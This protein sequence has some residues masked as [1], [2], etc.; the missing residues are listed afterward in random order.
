MDFSAEPQR[1]AA[2]RKPATETHKSL[3]GAQTGKTHPH[4]RLVKDG[5]QAAQI[6]VQETPSESRFINLDA[7]NNVA[8]KVQATLK[9][10]RLESDDLDTAFHALDEKTSFAARTAQEQKNAARQAQLT[11]EVE[12]HF[13]DEERKVAEFEQARRGRGVFRKIADAASS[14]WRGTTPEER[15]AGVKGVGGI[16]GLFYTQAQRQAA[17]MKK[18]VKESEMQTAAP[19]A[20]VKVAAPQA[21]PD[22]LEVDVDL[23]DL[24]TADSD[25]VPPPSISGTRL[26]V[27]DWTQDDEVQAV[28]TKPL[29]S[30]RRKIVQKQN[31]LLDS[32]QDVRLDSDELD[33]A[34]EG[35]DEHSAYQAK[36]ANEVNEHVM[37]ENRKVAEFEATR[38]GRGFF[39]KL[40]D[41]ASYVWKGTTPEERAAGD[42]GVGGIRSLFYTQAQRQAAFLKKATFADE[43]QQTAPVAVRNAKS[44]VSK[45]TASVGGKS[46]SWKTFRKV[47]LAGVIGGGAVTI[48]ISNCV[49]DGCGIDGI[50]TT[51]RSKLADTT[52]SSGGGGNGNEVSD[53]GVGGGSSS[54]SNGRGGVDT[55]AGGSSSG[56]VDAGAGGS[57]NVANNEPPVTPV[58]DLSTNTGTPAVP[59]IPQGT[60]GTTL[61]QPGLPRATL[62]K[63]TPKAPETPKN[64]EP[65]KVPQLAECKDNDVAGVTVIDCVVPSRDAEIAKTSLN[66]QLDQQQNALDKIFEPIT[67]GPVYV[68]ITPFER[69]RQP[70]NFL[71][72]KDVPKGQPRNLILERNGQYRKI[73]ADVIAKVRKE[74]AEAKTLKDF[75]TITVDEAKIG[76]GLDQLTIER[77]KLVAANF[78]AANIDDR[79]VIVY[80][81]GDLKV[82]SGQP[83]NYSTVQS[84]GKGITIV[85]PPSLSNTSETEMFA[86]P[87]ASNDPDVIQKYV[88]EKIAQN[89]GLVQVADAIDDQRVLF[90]TQD[91]KTVEALR[92]GRKV[93]RVAS[94]SPIA[95]DATHRV[96]H[97]MRISDSQRGFYTVHSTF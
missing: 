75:N 86:P 89:R 73:M 62:P 50:P 4:L 29:H 27:R 54:A 13:R 55:G 72:D 70:I 76:E 82:R 19:V 74:L 88:L 67:N 95:R 5:E 16:R 46:S 80:T 6:H 51:P 3:F 92:S 35:F 37:N 63:V 81:A 10:E 48:G 79:G 43:P 56:G 12:D 53:S 23:S 59:K 1:E 36:M 32:V 84:G 60:N 58:P 28:P 91:E 87:P 22:S 93:G 8:A 40:A 7:F 85:I 69:T 65:P 45:I 71:P 38:R 26:R 9:D 97:T 64:P 25:S 44:S 31:R 49:P 61:P 42:Q 94:R 47:A 90:P 52:S 2:R 57:P 96:N 17:L 77:Q 33:L 15:A 14:V 24:N 39:R 83:V 11:K 21:A 18:A 78:I 66:L 20:A 41:T 30:S 34:F 68:G